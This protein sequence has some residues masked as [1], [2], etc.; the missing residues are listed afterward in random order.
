MVQR[1]RLVEVAFRPR[2]LRLRRRVQFFGGSSL[3]PTLAFGSV[4][5]RVVL[6]RGCDVV[7]RL[8][9]HRGP[10]DAKVARKLGDCR[11][12]GGCFCMIARVAIFARETQMRFAI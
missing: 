8:R 6:A 7:L 1:D 5:A 9:L 10:P 4:P 2:L 11:K 3:P 12:L